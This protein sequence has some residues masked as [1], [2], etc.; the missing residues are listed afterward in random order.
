MNVAGPTQA[1]FFLH[2]TILQLSGLRDRPP[3]ELYGHLCCSTAAKQQQANSDWESS[4]PRVALE[5]LIMLKDLCDA[6]TLTWKRLNTN[7][8]KP[9]PWVTMAKVRRTLIHH[10]KA[11]VQEQS[12]NHSL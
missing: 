4:L 6:A 1:C 12:S 7:R 5:G 3:I 10:L 8:S 2:H 9:R 11:E